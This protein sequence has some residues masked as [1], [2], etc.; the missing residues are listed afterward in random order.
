MCEL[1]V[2]RESS[3]LKNESS[4]SEEVFATPRMMPKSAVKATVVTE[5]RKWRDKAEVTT[6][7]IH[8]E[9]KEL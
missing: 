4:S 6:N 5:A 1:N 3:T 8:R 7:V 9:Q 2:F